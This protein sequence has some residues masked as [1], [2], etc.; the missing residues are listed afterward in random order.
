MERR[1]LRWIWV[2]FLFVSA[3]KVFSEKRSDSDPLLVLA[4]LIAAPAHGKTV[5]NTVESGEMVWRMDREQ[6]PIPMERFVMKGSGLTTNRFVRT[7][8]S[9]GATT[10]FVPVDAIVQINNILVAL[11]RNW[12]NKGVGAFQFQ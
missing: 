2:R 8:G 7:N 4:S 10:Y 5:D 6:R 12:L 1:T 9:G 3:T 11:G